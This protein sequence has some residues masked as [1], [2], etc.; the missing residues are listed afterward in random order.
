V[1][2]QDRP[3]VTGR[4]VPET[5]A[6]GAARASARVDEAVVV[7]VP[8]HGRSVLQTAVDR[9]IKPGAAR[10]PESVEAGPQSLGIRVAEPCGRRSRAGTRVP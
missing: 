5:P 4:R 8:T 2:G 9:G 3:E 1:L 10:A 7:A 6:D